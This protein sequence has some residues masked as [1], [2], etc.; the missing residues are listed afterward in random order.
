MAFSFNW[1]G[2]NIPQI[3][4]KDNWAQSREDAMNLG[5]AVRGYQN[6]QAANEY[7][8]AIDRYRNNARWDMGSERADAQRI[9]A[10]IQRLQQENAEI[11]RMIKQQSSDIGVEPAVT[12]TPYDPEYERQAA[13]FSRFDPTNP[14]KMSMDEIKDVQSFIGLTGNDVDGVWGK[15]S[16]KALQRFVGVPEQDIDGVWGNQSKRFYDNYINY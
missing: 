7:A 13:I 16:T 14:K 2:V 12:E 1:A 5:K 11:D 9:E 3:Q 8:D 15:Q 6:R 10:E 4:V